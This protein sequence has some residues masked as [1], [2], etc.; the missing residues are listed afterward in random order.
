MNSLQTGNSCSVNDLDCNPAKSITSLNRSEFRLG[1]ALLETAIAVSCVRV[2]H[3]HNEH[4][5]D[6]AF[7]E[8]ED[9]RSQRE[10]SAWATAEAARAQLRVDIDNRIQDHLHQQMDAERESGDAE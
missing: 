1:D 8:L 6:E 2:G 7:A 4:E 10:R 9:L 3:A 5:H